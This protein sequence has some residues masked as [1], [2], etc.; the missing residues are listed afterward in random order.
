MKPTFIIFE[1]G[2]LTL[3]FPTMVEAVL[4]IESQ[5]RNANWREQW[6]FTYNPNGGACA[7]ATE[8]V[9]LHLGDSPKS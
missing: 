8:R 3:G 7:T 2:K 6:T 4:S 5:S 1:L 9:V